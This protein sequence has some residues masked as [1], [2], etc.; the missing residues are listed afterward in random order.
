ME[1]FSDL[2]KK[3]KA[4]FVRGTPTKESKNIIE[5]KYY[6][7]DDVPL[8]LYLEVTSSQDFNLLCYQG[9]PDTNE[10]LDK[11]EEIVSLHA[12]NTGNAEY[13]GYFKTFKAYQKMVNEW[14]IVRAILTRLSTEG[15][16][17]NQEWVDEL[18]RRRYKIQ[19]DNQEVYQSSLEAAE[20]RNEG[21]VTQILLKKKELE[22]YSK[23]DKKN[24]PIGFESL[25]AALCQGLGREVPDTI[26][27]ARYDEYMK[28]IKRKNRPKTTPYG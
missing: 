12:R 14:T 3:V 16:G 22:N 15:G 17:F 26:T 11:W 9:T 19:T 24:K 10:C 25:M 6:G 23:G 28:I 18:N 7:Y 4:L 2:L 8:K 20:R 5:S 27:L 13:I 21:M 1:I